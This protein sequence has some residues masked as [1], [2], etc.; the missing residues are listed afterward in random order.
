MQTIGARELK[1]NPQSAIRRV[2]ET[3][4]DLEVTVYGQPTGVRLSTT[5]RHRRAR[6]VPGA[7]LNGVPPLDDGETEDFLRDIEAPGDHDTLRD[8]FEGSGL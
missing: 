6:W 1:Q 5:P 4:E 8:P 3:G 2:L 7:V